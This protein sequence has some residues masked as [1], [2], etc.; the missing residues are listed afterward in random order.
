[1]DC[2]INMNKKMKKMM[3][4]AECNKVKPEKHSINVSILYPY[5]TKYT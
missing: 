5:T 1:M 4:K 2:G 3:M